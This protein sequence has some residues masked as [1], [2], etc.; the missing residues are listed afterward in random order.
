MQGKSLI[1]YT[2][3]VVLPKTFLLMDARQP[4]GCYKS[5]VL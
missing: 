5:S 1:Y 3:L 4:Y 2:F